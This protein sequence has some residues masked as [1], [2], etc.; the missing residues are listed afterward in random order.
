MNLT[1]KRV[2]L[3]KAGL[4]AAVSLAV[5]GLVWWTLIGQK[6]AW[7]FPAGAI[8]ILI[9]DALLHLFESRRARASIIRDLIK[10]EDQV[11]S[12]EKNNKI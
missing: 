2:Y 7:A 12:T 1:A 11:D 10:E 3:C 8:V 5:V 4:V 9:A 6:L